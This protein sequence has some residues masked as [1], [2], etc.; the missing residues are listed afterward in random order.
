[1]LTMHAKQTAKDARARKERR[2]AMKKYHK[3]RLKI[4]S[5]FEK[6]I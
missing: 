4:D 2:L 3:S 6:Q 5:L 1:M